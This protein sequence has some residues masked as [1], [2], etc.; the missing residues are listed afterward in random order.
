[1][2]FA[3]RKKYISLLMFYIRTLLNQKK[4]DEIHFW[5]FTNN[6][7]DIHYL[8]SI[9]N[10][11]K[12]SSHF[13][14]YREIFP[15]IYNKKFIIGIKSTK[16]GAYVLINDKYEIIFYKNTFYS[17][18]KNKINNEVIKSKCA[19][20]SKY[21]YLLYTF[22]INNYNFSITEKEKTLFNFKIED[23]NFSSVK[24][25]SE[26]NSENYWY[27]E[28]MKNQNIKLFDTEFR[29]KSHW[30]EAYKYY[31]TYDYE[32][33]LK[34]DDDI[35]YIDINRFD[36][37]IYFIRNSKINITI[38]NL[39]NHAVSLFYNN[40]YGLIPSEILN[41]KYANRNNSLEVY[42]Y[43]NDG[44]QANIIHQYFLNNMNKFINNKIEPINLNG[45]LPSICFFGIKKK[46]FVKVYQKTF[47]KK[48]RYN[49][50]SFDDERY[51]H[52]L[53][54]NYLF[55]KF[56]SVHYHFGPQ[57]N[58]LNETIFNYYKNLNL[59]HNGFNK[60]NL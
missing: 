19:K 25:H 27:Y 8:E 60:D 30:Y 42:D 2:V 59:T 26:K 12:S 44:K 48:A 23:N 43:Y 50:K 20:L 21:K 31:L 9:S 10:I 52:T 41:K 5:Q 57:R 45:Q 53:Y 18:F 51:A 38:P 39:I 54:N 33:L 24:I 37:Y 36:E 22:E 29:V 14:E 3:G 7:E 47:I 28:E 4:I 55:P 56:I 46:S 49:I 15:K 13:I 17:I 16:G 32:I 6:Q 40:K 35:V 11:H 34:M 58:E 1:M